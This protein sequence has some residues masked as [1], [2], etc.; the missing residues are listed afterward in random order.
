LSLDAGSFTSYDRRAPDARNEPTYK[1]QQNLAMHHSA[2]FAFPSAVGLTLSIS[3]SVS[4]SYHQHLI[5]FLR[6]HVG[7]TCYK[8]LK[9]VYFSGCIHIG[10]F[11][12]IK[13]VKVYVVRVLHSCMITC[14][15]GGS[16]VRW[17]VTAW[18]RRRTFSVNFTADESM[19]NVTVMTSRH[20]TSYSPTV[21]T[22]TRHRTCLPP[23]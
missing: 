12:D 18:R 13:H 6:Y 14:F 22:V 23:Q 7:C 10:I 5:A 1:F 17:S 9:A 11:I 19:E 15:G 8:L 20:S 2:N 16:C 4:S 3:K 21:T